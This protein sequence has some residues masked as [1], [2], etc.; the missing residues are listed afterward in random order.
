MIYGQSYE[1]FY[2]GM[3][4]NGESEKPHKKKKSWNLKDFYNL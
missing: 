2:A 4:S 1:R 3:E